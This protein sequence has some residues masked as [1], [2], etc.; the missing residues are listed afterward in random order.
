MDVLV[1]LVVFS[2]LATAGIVIAV[3]RVPADERTWLR[4]VLLA[5]FAVRA[6]VAA[7]F[8]VFSNWRIFHEDSEGYELVSIVVAQSWWGKAPPI[9]FSPTNSGYYYLG[10][11]LCFLFGPYRLN[12]PLFNALL[13]TAT[14]FLMY[15]WTR[16]LVHTRV[17]R[18]TV[19]LIAFMP[20][21]ILW[22]SIALKDTV[23]TF[24]IV[25][26]LV[27]C[28]RLKERFTF[29][30]ALGVVIPILLIQP[31]RFYL[32][33][34]LG[35]AVLGSLLFDR[36]VRVLT[37]VSKQIVVLGVIVALFVIT[38]LS[39]RVVQEAEFL[40]LERV[41]AFRT[42]M[43]TSARSGFG[44]DVDISTPG[45]ALAYLPV[46][47]SNL[48]F[49]PFPWQLSSIRAAVAMPETLAWWLLVPATWRGIRF[50]MRRRFSAI[51]P[52]ILFVITLTC[53]YSLMHGNIGSGFRQR[54]QI[55]VFLFTFSAVG[56]YQKKCR[57]VGIDEAAL[58]RQ[59]GVVAAS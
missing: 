26:A 13:G 27:S 29:G 10:G 35:F 58:L 19:M 31:I 12:L 32:I 39:G 30:S 8:A 42:G 50:L 24:L 51:S 49:G 53:A 44:H 5:A 47:I 56:W 28:V 55:F 36:G 6:F 14:M 9:D 45:K 33:Y 16:S 52:V 4:N 54:S 23:T 15:Y 3:R 18:L 57:R 48:L 59:P 37:G 41:S 34:F 2:V 43:A 17:A 38:G 46:G 25:V 40:K 22:N 7:V 21:M 1:P 20:S 11:A